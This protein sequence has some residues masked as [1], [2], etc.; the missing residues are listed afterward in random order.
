MTPPPN[1]AVKPNIWCDPIVWDHDSPPY[2]LQGVLPGDLLVQFLG[3]REVRVTRRL[4]TARQLTEYE[5]SRF[6]Q[7]H[8]QVGLAFEDLPPSTP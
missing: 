6:F 7:N 8:G 2:F 5:Q 3:D 4:L 1:I